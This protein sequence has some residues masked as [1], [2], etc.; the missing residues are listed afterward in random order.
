MRPVAL[1]ALLVLPLAL[2]A[3]ALARAQQPPAGPFVWI[4]G[5]SAAATTF[6]R[7]NWYCCQD[8]RRDL[9]S[10]GTPGGAAGD[11]LAHYANDG[12]AVTAEYRFAA[13]AAGTYAL[14][15][16][17]SA[18]T[19]RMRYQVDAGDWRSI[20]TESDPR[21]YQNLL[22]PGKIDLRFLAWVRAGDVDLTA[23]DHRLVLELSGHPERQGGREV[24]GGIDVVA[25]AGFPWTPAGALR[26]GAGPAPGPGVWYPL[27]AEDDPL[28]PASITDMHRLVPAPAGLHGPVQAVGDALAF[29]DGNPVRFWGLDAQPATTEALQRQQA[30]YYAKQGVNLVRLHPV[31]D[32]VGLLVKDPAS[33]ERRF[34]ATRLDRLDRWFA[35]LKEQGLYSDWSVF[36]PHVITP[37]DGYDPDLYAELAGAGVGKSTSGMVNFMRPLQDAE[38]EYLRRLLDHVNPYTGLR[39][40]ADPALAIV[41]VH[42]EDSVFWH[43]PLNDLEPGTR[44]PRHT[45]ELQRLWMEWLRGRYASDAELLAAWGPAHNGSRPGDSLTNPRMP[46]YGAWEMDG[47][48]PVRNANERRRMGDFIRFLAE[49]QR[50]YF[51]RR[52]A[53]LRA[54]GFQG[55]RVTTAW[56]AGGPAASLANLWT[57]DALDAI[58][59]HHY[60]GGGDGGWRIQPG[61]VNNESHL[62]TPGGGVLGSGFEQVEGKP[63][64]MTEWSQSPPNQW[65]A[66]IAPLVAF[67]GMSLQGWDAS[68]HF[69]G[70]LPRMG[71]GWPGLSSFVSETPHYLGQF[72]ALALAVQRGDIRPGDLAA[73]RRLPVD[74]AFRGYDALTGTTPG[75]GWGAGS[76]GGDLVTP[77]DTFAMGRV[78]TRVADG[79]PRSER[80]DWAARRSGDTVSSTTGELAWNAKS[81]V[82]TVSSPRT[83]AVIGFAG[84]GRYDLPGVTVEVSASTP[85]VSLI[86]TALDDRL[87]ADSTH[88]LV[89]ALAR[90]AQLGARYNADGSQLEEL[91]GPPLL[92]EPVQARLTFRTP[93]VYSARPA[94]IHG[95]PRDQEVE[96]QGNT[97][98]IDGR[99]TAYYYEVRASGPDLGTAT[100]TVT[101]VATSLAT[102]TPPAATATPTGAVTATTPAGSPSATAVVPP[103]A[104][105]P[106]P[107]GRVRI[108]LPAARRGV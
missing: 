53:E 76:T 34:D 86:V 87:V 23:G 20:D 88:I 40:A 24:H 35:V 13:P 72:P 91:G 15:L 22:A 74:D 66:E 17:I 92:L 103:S 65:K 73:A 46:V 69:A 55:L 95:V 97:I 84:G 10:P 30:R 31:E 16:R 108:Y 51:A 58:D 80:T 45:A 93:M 107:V 54:L 44:Y 71:S 67:Y 27:V 79:Q 102:A 98:T 21:E 64:I 85:F 33:G 100:P 39:Y 101:P 82:V 104:T 57:D 99:Y 48:G 89:T 38:W 3:P 8:L 52:G 42:N 78:I 19:V 11:W 14:W 37:D 59:R 1:L 90:D 105:P 43:A 68:M 36:Y 9:L 7:H 41:E 94:D 32:M 2:G 70:S 56:Q 47:R 83:Q 96:R 60:T 18:Y 4:E 106:G 26:P 81:R 61:K 75:G 63:Y 25:L 50:A 5:E 62:A 6:N 77:L 29:A 49:T 28:S 12:R